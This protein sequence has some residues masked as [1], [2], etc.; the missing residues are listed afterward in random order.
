MT[1]TRLFRWALAEGC[2]VEKP[3]MVRGEYHEPRGA[4]IPS[5]SYCVEVG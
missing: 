4:W 3:L 1:I 2:C 5:G